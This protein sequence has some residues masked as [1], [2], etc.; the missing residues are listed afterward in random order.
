MATLEENRQHW[1]TYSW[2]ERGDEWSVRWGG[3][4]FLWYGMLYPRIMNFIP[5]ACG[6]EIA[7]GHGRITQF[8][9]DHCREL[10][11]VDLA[12]DCIDVCRERFRK[13]SN[14][15]YHVN[16]GKSLDFI[17][18]H[19]LDFVFSFDSLVHAEA[20]VLRSYL[21]QLAQK[22]T[23]HGVGF[24]HHSNMAA[25][26]DP[27]AQQLSCPNL[28][29][30]AE[31]VS[32]QLFRDACD[33]YSLECIS[34]ELIYWGKPHLVGQLND[35]FS[36]FTL[37]GSKFSRPLRVRENK[38]FMNEATAILEVSRLYGPR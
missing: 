30:R 28:H 27:E 20:D 6:L 32:A 31:S 18:D 10:I 25:F 13:D 33:E 24:L 9:K 4:P 36:V 19:S 16:D 15:S 2:S 17:A 14:I 5:A 34:Q 38:G 8:L 37:K 22:L 3:T 21:Q 7:P 29:W 12:A 1:S 35:C 11:I 26:R 23:P